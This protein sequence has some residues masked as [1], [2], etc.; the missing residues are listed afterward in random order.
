[1]TYVVKRFRN[2]GYSRLYTARR[3]EGGAQPPGLTE[4][5]NKRHV[6]NYR[7][8]TSSYVCNKFNDIL[9]ISFKGIR[10][11]SAFT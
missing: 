4:N 7:K 10:P 11:S 9:N 6:S 8:G 3:T 2:L 5:E 1:M